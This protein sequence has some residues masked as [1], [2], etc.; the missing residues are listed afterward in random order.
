M[1]IKELVKKLQE[2]DQ[3]AIVIM[4]CDG[5]GNNFSPLSD[6]ES[7]HYLAESTCNGE[8]STDITDPLAVVLYPI[9]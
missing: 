6:L 7:S 1:L 5:E 3:N 9:N 4:S 2:Q 8:L